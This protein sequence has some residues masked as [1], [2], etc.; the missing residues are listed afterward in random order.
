M[1]GLKTFLYERIDRLEEV[2]QTLAKLSQSSAEASEHAKLKEI[3]QFIDPNLARPIDR[4]FDF[5]IQNEFETE[6]EFDAFVFIQN[7]ELIQNTGGKQLKKAAD[8]LLAD[9][10]ISLEA[11]EQLGTLPDS[12]SQ[13]TAPM[14]IILQKL[15][16]PRVK[17]LL[18]NYTTYIVS[19]CLENESISMHYGENLKSIVAHLSKVVPPIEPE[20]HPG[21]DAEITRHMEIIFEIKPGPHKPSTY[22]EKVKFVAEN[23]KAFADY[24]DAQWTGSVYEIMYDEKLDSYAKYK[25]LKT[26][27]C[28]EIKL[29]YNYLISIL[30]PE[31][32][33]LSL[34]NNPH[35]KR[36]LETGVTNCPDAVEEIK[37]YVLKLK[38]LDAFIIDDVARAVQFHDFYKKTAELIKQREHL[39]EEEKRDNIRIMNG[40]YLP[41][42]YREFNYKIDAFRTALKRFLDPA[43]IKELTDVKKKGAPSDTEI[44]FKHANMKRVIYLLEVMTPFIE[45]AAVKP[46]I[47]TAEFEALLQKIREITEQTKD[48][49]IHAFGGNKL[50]TRK[51]IKRASKKT[52]KT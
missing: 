21:D 1:Q 24:V 50:R 46:F 36:I 49:F 10:G 43:A 15:K 51:H 3:K 47:Q 12:K 26:P 31:L 20:L 6:E 11:I 44:H 22:P 14:E 34:E 48:S 9:H 28:S 23:E 52:R 40:Y 37:E 45:M 30:V 5:D 38:T 2:F 32:T 18:D 7:L 42:L 35:I 27:L 17:A 4:E 33:K 13:I 8:Q 16:D 29:K 41:M 39:K 25:L 19:Q